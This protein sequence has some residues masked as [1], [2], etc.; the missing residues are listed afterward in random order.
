MPGMAPPPRRL[1]EDDPASANAVHGSVVLL[2]GSVRTTRGACQPT[3]P[4]PVG[5]SSDGLG[6]YSSF[7]KLGGS[8]EKLGEF[9]V[10]RP[11]LRS[12]QSK[13]PIASLLRI[14]AIFVAVR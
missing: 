13:S 14:S 4:A 8:R 7:Q 12:A 11:L 5:S 10:R 9:F 2:R 3:T 1:A 6:C